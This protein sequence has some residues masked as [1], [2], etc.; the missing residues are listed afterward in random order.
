[1]Q[2][3]NAMLDRSSIHLIKATIRGQRGRWP[4]HGRIVPGTSRYWA[5]L[6]NTASCKKTKNRSKAFGCD[7]LKLTYVLAK[8]LR[9]PSFTRFLF[10]SGSK[11]HITK[12]KRG[13]EER[14]WFSSLSCSS[15]ILND[16]L[17]NESFSVGSLAQI[18]T[19]RIVSPFVSKPY[20][21][22]YRNVT[23]TE[24]K[25]VRLDLSSLRITDRFRD[26]PNGRLLPLRHHKQLSCQL[27]ETLH[28]LSFANQ[29]MPRHPQLAIRVMHTTAGS[30]CV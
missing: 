8:V 10:S 28:I 19:N 23:L 5:K 3:L 29:S 1:M 30:V 20:R 27:Q 4:Y 2:C 25:T 6:Q 9:P 26:L 24:S 7:S 21:G 14:S 22:C 18:L 15:S 17:M 11:Q 16:N 12:R 13:P